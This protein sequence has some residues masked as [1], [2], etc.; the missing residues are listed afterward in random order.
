VALPFALAHKLMLRAS[1][2]DRYS[3]RLF[4]L[5]V[6]LYKCCAECCGAF[7]ATVFK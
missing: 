3:S 7:H 5:G 2:T 1:F 4:G 6:K